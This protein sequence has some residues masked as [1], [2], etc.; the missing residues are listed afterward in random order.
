MLLFFFKLFTTPLL[1][2]LATLVSRRYGQSVAGWLV[3]LP[4][5]SG[6]IAVFLAI[7]NGTAF[8]EAAALGSLQGTTAQAAFVVA[9]SRC[10]RRTSWPVALLLACGAFGLSGTILE[11]IDLGALPLAAIAVAALSAGLVAAKAPA[12]LAP[13]AKPPR[14]DLLV[15]MAVAALLVVAVTAS[16]RA[17]GPEASGL[18]ATFPLFASILGVF[19]QR[20]LGPAA[21]QHALRGLLYGLYSFTGF[22]VTVHFLIVPLGIAACIACAIVIA[23]AI[24]WITYR[25]L[26][27]AHP[28]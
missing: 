8:S 15:R 12:P 26:R 1:I 24:H 13:L 18:L 19:A 14:S 16:S 28:G 23:L 11:V 27:R 25:M 20:Q 5:T 3:G 21:A 17:L 7:D 6:P 2:A 9:Y 22:F 10:A 4:L